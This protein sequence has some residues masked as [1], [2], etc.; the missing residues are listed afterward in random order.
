MIR[1]GV[2]GGKDLILKQLFLSVKGNMVVLNTLCSVVSV[3]P[4]HSQVFFSGK[5]LISKNLENLDQI[6]KVVEVFV[7]DIVA[8]V[9]NVT[10]KMDNYTFELR[11]FVIKYLHLLLSS[12]IQVV[13]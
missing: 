12:Q 1:H 6:K 9:R 4:E 7:R 10:R 11:L 8:S 3:G 2:V 5:N 13:V